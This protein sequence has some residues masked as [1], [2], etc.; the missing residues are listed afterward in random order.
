MATKIEISHR[1]IIFTLVLLLGLWVLLQI[2]DIIFLLF[3]SFILMAALR[4]VVDWLERFR[5]PRIISILLIYFLVFGVFGI[6]VAGT[7]PTLVA[8]STRLIQVFPSVVERVLPYWNID[9]K[10]LSAQI[11]PLGE[12]VVKLT[13]SIFSNLVTTLAV[14]V[15]TF[16][17]LLERK[18]IEDL[19]TAMFGKETAGNT[20][21]VI[22]AIE[23]RLGAWVRGQLLLMLVIGAAVYLG[24]ILLKVE[25]ALALGIL[26][27]LL[28]IVPVVGP[29]MAAIPAVLVALTTSPLLAL[30]VV[31]LY[32]VIQQLENNLLVPLVMR[33]SVGLSPLV[34]IVTLMVGG[35]LAGLV[36]AI[37]SVPVLLVIQEVMGA[38]LGKSAKEK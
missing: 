6:S 21:T 38:V 13:V 4:P 29:I 11:A 2:R 31:A 15:F 16:Y 37:L 18:H 1:T 36:G 26:A 19:L 22:R 17:F 24:L 5:L 7:I 14:L 9:L 12:N 30:T 34:T 25:F 20:M 3:I 28:E 23:K 33:R 27:G 32:F 10:S 8:Q 35:R